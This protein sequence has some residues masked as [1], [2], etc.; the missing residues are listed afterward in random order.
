MLFTLPMM[1]Y[2]WLMSVH[3]YCYHIFA[4]SS[5]HYR[6]VQFTIGRELELLLS[7]IVMYCCS[8]AGIL[9]SG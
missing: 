6:I 1:F 4:I 7:S 8:D 5:H 3:Y 9:K 2:L